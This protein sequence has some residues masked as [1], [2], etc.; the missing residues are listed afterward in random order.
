MLHVH[1]LL[2]RSSLGLLDGQ[3][4][5]LLEAAA[6]GVVRRDSHHERRGCLWGMASGAVFRE[7]ITPGCHRECPALPGAT[8]YEPMVLLVFSL[9]I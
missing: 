3:L 5:G 7:P 1:V 8:Y 9:A 2:L 4:D 6:V